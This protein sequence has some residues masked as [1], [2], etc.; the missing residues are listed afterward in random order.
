MLKTKRD[1]CCGDGNYGWLWMAVTHLAISSY[2]SIWHIQIQLAYPGDYRLRWGDNKV[3]CT[4]HGLDEE[5][6]DGHPGL[7]GNPG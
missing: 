5:S 7:D 4:A 1:S 6:Q 2:I 3:P